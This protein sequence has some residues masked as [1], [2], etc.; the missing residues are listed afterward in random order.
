M[1]DYP[2]LGEVSGDRALT[3]VLREQHSG[4]LVNLLH[5]GDAI[6]MANSLE[7]RMPFLDHRLVEYVWPL[8]SDYKV[9]LGVGKYLHREAMRG[10]VPDPI[11]DERSKYGFT[12]PIGIQFVKDHASGSGPVDILLSDRCLE[13]GLFDRSGLERLI[14]AHRSGKQNHGSLLFRLLSTELWFRRFVDDA[15]PGG[16][17]VKAAGA[18]GA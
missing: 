14:A 5:Y 7:A 8:P 3:R 6:S 13:R 15:H 9:R 18:Q 4:G 17:Q 2:D 16:D 12:T 1:R 11:L 10:V